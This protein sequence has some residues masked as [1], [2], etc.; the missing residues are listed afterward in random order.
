MSVAL[1]VVALIVAIASAVYARRVGVH[2]RRS[3]DAAE[4]TLRDEHKPLLSIDIDRPGE[5]GDRA[6]YRVR[7]DGPQDLDEVVIYRPRPPDRIEYHIAVTGGGG[8]WAEDEITLGGLRLTQQARF[9]LSCGNA[10]TLPEFR[11]RIECRSGK[12]RWSIPY[13]LPSPRVPSSIVP[14]D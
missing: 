13:L 7:N 4:K 6:I 5:Q 8:G 2:T 12:D 11:V 1:S 10:P 3:A 9:T 14:L